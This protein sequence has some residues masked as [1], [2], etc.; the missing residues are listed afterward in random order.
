MC[1]YAVCV[2]G[3]ACLVAFAEVPPTRAG[4]FKETLHGVE[5]A[6]PYRWLEDQTS[7]ETRAWLDAQNVHTKSVLAT[8]AG[9]DKI[10]AR[11]LALSRTDRADIPFARGGR[12]FFRKRLTDQE[13]YLLVMR[14]PSESVDRILVDPTAATKDVN[15]SANIMDVSMDGKLMAYGIREGGQ[16]ELQVKV[17]QVDTREPLRDILPKRRYLTVSFMPD[18]SGVFY[19]VS[20]DDKPRVFEHK[21]GDD[22]GND[23]AIFGEGFGEQHLLVA[24]VSDDGRY[25]VIEVLHGASADRVDVYV[26]DLQLQAQS[27]RSSK[28]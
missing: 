25:L 14:E 6:D 12:Y 2:L 24:A 10:K 11:L 18:K 1:R 21:F 23:R 15:T 16:D 19:T 4:N 3:S 13:Q 28:T 5:I 27:N 7:A 8:Y 17:L 9:R 20:G 26:K 22:P